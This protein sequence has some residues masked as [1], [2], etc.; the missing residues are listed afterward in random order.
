MSLKREVALEVK[1]VL[2]EEIVKGRKS[3]GFKSFI[4]KKAL[5][6]VKRGLKRGAILIV[7]FSSNH[8][9]YFKTGFVNDNLLEIDGEGYEFD[10]AA[11][12]YYGRKKIPAYGV[13]EWRLSPIGGAV[14]EASFKV[15]KTCAGRLDKDNADVANITN[16]AQRT[17]IRQIE[18]KELDPSKKKKGGK[19]NLVWI[20]IGGAIILYFLFKALGGA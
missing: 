2:F 10:P 17:I 11:F 9:L 6:K 13:I 14:D 19:M 12:F 3:K 16:A 7:F 1:K 8:T 18:A 4:D 15:W 20:L 5:A